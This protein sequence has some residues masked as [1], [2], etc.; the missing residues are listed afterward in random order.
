MDKFNEQTVYKFLFLA[1]ILSFSLAISAEEAFY[2]ELPTKSEVKRPPSPEENSSPSVVIKKA[3]QMR[4]PGAAASINSTV[5]QI[6]QRGFREVNDE[7]LLYLS[8]DYIAPQFTPIEEIVGNTTTPLSTFL[9][10]PGIFR[11]MEL[12]GS[13]AKG[14]TKEKNSWTQISRYYYL[15]N[16]SILMFSEFDYVA[17][18]ISTA[19]P[20]ELVNQKI[21]DSPAMLITLKSTNGKY[22]SKLTWFTVDKL[23]SLHIT[24]R[25]IGDGVTKQL[26][27]LAQG[28][29]Q[30]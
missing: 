15:S 6:R 19:F 3:S 25:A 4:S 10:I 26:V 30:P 9:N 18:K 1:F 11:K 14:P 28:I 17:A 22:V 20:E 8:L 21:N 2:N 29:Q 16:G 7:D 5:E 27:A 23:Y 13:I 12:I 24:D